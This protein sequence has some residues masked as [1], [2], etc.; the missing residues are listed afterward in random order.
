MSAIDWFARFGG[1][2]GYAR[3]RASMRARLDREFWAK[4]DRST[5]CWLW[6]GGRQTPSP[7][8]PSGYGKVQVNGR[9][10][11]AH[12]RAYELACGPIPVGLQVL[13]RCDTPLCIRPAHLF[14]G[15]Q[16]DNMADMAA[17]GRARN[18]A[19]VRA[20]Q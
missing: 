15:T 17:K 9:R 1:A 2:D 10:V 19:L 6:T 16:A 3:S 11:F 4:T 18:S 12:R 7:T 14:L 5:G 13:H 8:S 20:A